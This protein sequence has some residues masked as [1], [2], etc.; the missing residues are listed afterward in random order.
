MR[1]TLTTLAVIVVILALAPGVALAEDDL[2]LPRLDSAPTLEDFLS[3]EPSAGF[4]SMARV[5][6]GFI[7]RDPVDGDP[8]SQH[9]D[10]Y[11]GYDD[12][13]LYVV[14]V[15]FDD[16]P[17]KIRAHLSRR[18]NLHGDDAVEI[19]LDTFLDH[20]QAY[21]F[22][23][24]P[25]G[26]QWDAIWN[27]GGDFDRSWDTVW[28][29]RGQLTD[30]G[31]V[32][33]IS[34]PFKSLRF[35]DTGE[36]HWGFLLVRD[37]PRNNES[38]FYP[39]MTKRVQSRL[40]Q[41]GVMGGI[42]GISPGRNAQINPYA[43]ARSFR[44]AD[45][46]NAV[47]GD[48]IRDQEFDG[49]LDAKMVFKD[50][51]VLD[52][53]ANPDFSQ[54]ESDEPQI[55]VNER[56]ELFFPEKRPFFLENA[57]YFRTPINLLFTRRIAD[58]RAGVRLT[59]KTGRNNFGLLFIDDEAPGKL[60][61][62]GDIATIGTVRYRRDLFR[63]SSVGLLLTDRELG[64]GYNRVASVDTRM[65]IG[66]KWVFSGQAAESRTRDTSG[67]KTSGGLYDVKVDG[68]GRH[69]GNHSHISWI[70]P[71]FRT[72]LGF[73]TRTGIMNAHHRTGWTFWPEGERLISWTPAVFLMTIEDTDGLRLDHHAEAEIDFQFRKQT[74]L[75]L[76]CSTGR[77]RLRPEDHN[78]LAEARDYPV[79]NCRVE[80]GTRF[81]PRF[82]LDLS[83]NRGHVVN[84]APIAGMEPFPADIA[85]W[86]L[87][88]SLLP[89]SPLRIDLTWITR[90]LDDAAGP[91]EIV[92]NRITRMRVNWQFSRRTSL[93]AIVQYDDI[94]ANPALTSRESGENLN[95]DLLF[96]WQVN[97]WTAFYAGYNSNWS[98]RMFEGDGIDRQ[99]V[100]APG[101]KL[102][103]GRQLFLKYSYLYRF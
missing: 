69:F 62:S 37:I 53:T 92:D 75:E 23:L 32:V 57:D 84:F 64:D 18:D 29:S 7:Q 99:L 70:D 24:N 31:Y 38:S 86:E 36:Q 77:Q 43:T 26:V 60:N 90:Q 56:F 3:M 33:W 83:Y 80:F 63:Q 96:T 9:T 2:T 6:G 4:A 54:V 28:Q 41:E 102:N 51:M 39:Q 91:A 19:Q 46:D 45:G 72:D 22:L 82:S 73:V 71:E 20:R 34:I 42:R 12:L 16:E 25:L 58:P 65:R 50:A 88:L 48:F 52:F 15:A 11:L 61:G 95:G 35:P 78:E 21:T 94:R 14:F 59:G 55:T 81:S 68:S 85:G 30:Q 1:V 44:L 5:N 79:D 40:S 67:L 98:G 89:V 47:T 10:V 101:L 17:D 97:P 8:A 13:N 27:E 74:E 87:E 66:P 100:P 76:N 49:G 103:D 93:R